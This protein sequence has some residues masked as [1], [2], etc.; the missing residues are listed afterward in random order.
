MGSRE[1]RK[2]LI[3]FDLVLKISGNSGKRHEDNGASPGDE[4]RSKREFSIR[5]RLNVVCLVLLKMTR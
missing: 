3:D 1:S 5:I 2:R 4:K